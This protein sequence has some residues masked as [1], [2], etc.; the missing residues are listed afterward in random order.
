[1]LSCHQ[2]MYVTHFGSNY[3]TANGE[4][5]YAFVKPKVCLYKKG[6]VR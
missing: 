2:K 4:V 1:M 5:L 3:I 6:H